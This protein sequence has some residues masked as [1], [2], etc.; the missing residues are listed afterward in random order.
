MSIFDS[1]KK[2]NTHDQEFRSAREL[3]QV[4]EY[5]EW[6][7]FLPTIARAKLACKNS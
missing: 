1:I 6:S 2:I 7:K 5:T 4:L 3:L